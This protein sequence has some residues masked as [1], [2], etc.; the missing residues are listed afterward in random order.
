LGNWHPVTK[1]LLGLAVLALPYLAWTA[2]E[3][4]PVTA[5]A[6]SR[7]PIPPTEQGSA[8]EL[9]AE[10]QLLRLPAV[11]SFHA[12]LER[13]LFVADRK[14]PAVAA[15]PT[16]MPDEGPLETEAP[17][18]NDG[19]ELRFVGTVGRDGAM[20]ALVLRGEQTEVMRLVV[21]DEID[22]WTVADVRTSELV[23][24]HEDERRV[25]TILQ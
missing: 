10:P 2:Q 12:M 21:G 16:V 5:A 8:P 17:T 19:P 24:E 25:L 1:L 13:P 4:E 11:E 20:T 15:E 6:R 22:G 3:D 7:S 23:I 14:P 9:V 18:G